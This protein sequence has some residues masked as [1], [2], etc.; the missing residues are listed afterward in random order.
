[1]AQL[2]AALRLALDRVIDPETDKIG[3]AFPTEGPSD[4]RLTT[5]PDGLYNIEFTSL[6]PDFARAVVHASAIIGVEATTT[7]L[8]A[9]ERGEPVRIHMSTVLNNL[10]LA[11]SVS[12]RDDVHVVSAGLDDVPTASRADHR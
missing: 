11:A 9:W 12:P 10:F 8:A 7:L 5:R 1:M 2:V 3:H 6:L 4:S